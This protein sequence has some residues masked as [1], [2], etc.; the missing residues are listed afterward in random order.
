M[1]EN[2]SPNDAAIRQEIIKTNPD[3]ITIGTPTNGQIKVYGDLDRPEEFARKIQTAQKL[4]SD[5][6]KAR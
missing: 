3:S 2:E 1:S 6:T 4:L 5:A